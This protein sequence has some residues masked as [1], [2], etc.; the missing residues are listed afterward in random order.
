MVR[1]EAE[2]TQ[3]PAVRDA[4]SDYFRRHPEDLLEDGTRPTVLLLAPD[5]EDSTSFRQFLWRTLLTV[6]IFTVIAVLTQSVID[7]IGKQTSLHQG[8]QLTKVPF[9]F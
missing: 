5:E 2:P 1:F 9:L 3:D 4:V 8:S 6:V 7:K